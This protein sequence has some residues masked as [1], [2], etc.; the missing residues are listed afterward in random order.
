MSD[1]TY[2]EAAW[3]K[4]TEYA[5]WSE[6]PQTDGNQG[7]IHICVI[8]TRSCSCEHGE[9]GNNNGQPESC[10]HLR[11]AIEARKDPKTNL[12]VKN[13]VEGERGTTE[14]SQTDTDN[15]QSESSAAVDE[16]AE[17]LQD[18][19]AA[20]IADMRVKTHN[21]RI[22]VQTGQD[23]PDTL[24]LPGA[25]EV[26]NVFLKEPDQIEYVHENHDL[27]SQKPGEW[28]KNTIAAGDV[29]EYVEEVLQ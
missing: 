14:A 11:C 29:E 22:W 7:K 27:H 23:T 13:Y 25:P 26:F 10:K 17:Y 16:M 4:G 1:D 21:G 12:T 6:D 5:V 8:E 18:S 15:S 9:K 3:I 2:L 20:V 24:D 19:F 28:W